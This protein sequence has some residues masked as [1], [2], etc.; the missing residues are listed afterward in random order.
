MASFTAV[1]D[2]SVPVGFSHGEVISWGL[3]GTFTGSVV[4]ESSG[5]PVTGPWTVHQTLS[6]ETTTTYPHEGK[7][8]WYR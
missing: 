2:V 8:R 7:N 1:G 5:S 6:T 3:A 4:L